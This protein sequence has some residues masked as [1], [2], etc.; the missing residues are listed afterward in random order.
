MKNII[1]FV[2]FLFLSSFKATLLNAQTPEPTFVSGDKGLQ[3]NEILRLQMKD[4]LKLTNAQFD[5]TLAIQKEFLNRFRQVKTNTKLT[6]DAK[7]KKLKDLLDMKTKRLKSAGLDD[8]AIKRVE[9]YFI[10]KQ[11]LP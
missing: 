7:K 9:D 1:W 11:R 10:N 3:K 8:A 6:E 5:S 2:F 4:D